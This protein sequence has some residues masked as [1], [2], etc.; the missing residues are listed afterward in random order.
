MTAYKINMD[1][2]YGA[3]VKESAGYKAED[4]SIIEGPDPN[5]RNGMGKRK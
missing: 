4:G 2:Y 1:R 5:E 3:L